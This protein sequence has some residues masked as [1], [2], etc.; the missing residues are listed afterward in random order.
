MTTLDKCLRAI[1]Q[2]F[3][4]IRGFT[5]NQFDQNNSNTGANIFSEEYR[6]ELRFAKFLVDAATT[7]EFNFAELFKIVSKSTWEITVEITE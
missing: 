7:I 3:R 5:W 6:R 1:P 4:F 2:D